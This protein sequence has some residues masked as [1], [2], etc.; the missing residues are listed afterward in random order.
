MSVVAAAVLISC[1]STTRNE[2]DP[3]LLYNHFV[4][5][6]DT[7]KHAD[8][9]MAVC[10]RRRHRPLTM[11]SASVY[12]VCG[13]AKR[14]DFDVVVFLAVSANEMKQFLHDTKIRHKLCASVRFLPKFLN[15]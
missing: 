4:P 12:A 6:T 7:R 14:I 13:L 1:D 11:T 9:A 5:N 15:L 8:Y 10:Y 3:Y 2:V